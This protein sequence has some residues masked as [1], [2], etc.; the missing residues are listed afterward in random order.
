MPF[1]VVRAFDGVF[2]VRVDRLGEPMTVPSLDL[3]ILVPFV[4]TEQEADE[5]RFREFPKVRAEDD[6]A[7]KDH[8]LLVLQMPEGGGGGIEKGIVTTRQ[9]GNHVAGGRDPHLLQKPVQPGG[10]REFQRSSPSTGF[11]LSL[12]FS[13]AQGTMLR[14]SRP[15]MATGKSGENTW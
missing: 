4:R 3:E 10:I 2:L 12:R 15:T 14:A 8:L 11:F 5:A 7:E 1:R 9:M 6:F 13:K